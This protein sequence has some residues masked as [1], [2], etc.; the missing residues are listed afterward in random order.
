M[1]QLSTVFLKNG[2]LLS[3]PPNAVQ[4]IEKWVELISDLRRDLIDLFFAVFPDPIT[5]PDNLVSLEC[6]RMHILNNA[7]LY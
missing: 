7:H 4:V 1:V 5:N 2:Q 3:H 6:E